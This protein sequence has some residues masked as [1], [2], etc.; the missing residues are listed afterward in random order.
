MAES[1][2]LRFQD[3][4]GDLLADACKDLVDVKEEFQCPPCVANPYASV[5][6]WKE[7]D[8]NEPFFNERK[9]KFE[10]T[11]ETPYTTTMDDEY[12][13]L[14]RA[15]ELTEELE[16]EGLN[17]RFDEF[18]DIA[19]ESLLVNNSREDS[20]KSRETV[21]NS[22]EYTDIYLDA[23]P[24][25]RLKL[26][27]SVSFETIGSIE[28]A[29]D[30]EEEEE[31]E[32]SEEEEE[33][34]S[35]DSPEA[36]TY[37]ADEIRTKLNRVRRGLKL[38]SKYLKVHRAVEG[39]NI[40]K[41]KDNSVFNLQNYGD[42]AR[43]G[44]ST[45]GKL[46][47]DLDDFLASK[48]L[49]IVAVGTTGL[50]KQKVT[51]IEFN[52]T[53]KYKLKRLRVW[54]AGCGEQPF[55][56]GPKKLKP[57]NAKDSWRDPTAVA[58]FAQ[59]DK[60][61]DSLTATEPM[62]W[63]EFVLEYTY[64][65]LYSTFG[66]EKE[67][68]APTSSCIAARL[69]EETKQLGQNILDSA[70]SIGDAVV[71]AFRKS[72]C[73]NNTQELEE[74]EIQ[75]GLR[76]APDA[77]TTTN[78]TK[79]RNV[80]GTKDGR[81]T[82][83]QMATEQAFAT[84][85]DEDQIFMSLCAKIA[86]FGKMNT[87]QGVRS[88]GSIDLDIIW[89]EGFDKIKKCGMFD[90]AIEA[91]HCLMKGLTLEQAGAAILKAALRA[92]SIDNLNDFFLRALPADRQQEVASL[93]R[94]KLDSGD[95]F[96]PGTE[97]SSLSAD[98]E[99]AEGSMAIITNPS[100]EE[101]LHE[102]ENSVE[103][104]NNAMIPQRNP[105]APTGPPKSDRTIA[106]T[107]DGSSTQAEF[108]NLIVVEAYI[109]ALIEI[110]RNDVIEAI[111][112]LNQYPGAQMIANILAFTDCP[113]APL[114]N[115][116]IPDFIN[117][118]QLPIC[119]DIDDWVMPRFQNPGAWLPKIKD[120]PK[121]F[122]ELFKQAL[123]Q[124][125]IG[126]VTKLIMKLCGLI[127]GSICQ[128]LKTAGSTLASLEDLAS[129]TASFKSAIRE[130]ICGELADEEEIDDTIADL[131][132]QLGA[133]SAALSDEELLQNFIS[134]FSSAVTQTEFM[135]AFLGNPSDEMLIAIDN[136]V[137]Y[138]YEELR[139]GFPNR[140]AIANFFENT[141][142]LIPVDVRD[143]MRDA[144]NN[145]P[146]ADLPANPSLC[147]TPEQQAAFCD[148]RN[149]LLQGR[150]SENQIGA[151]C[152][153]ATKDL[154]DN[155]EDLQDLLQGGLP[156]YINNNMPPLV[157]APGCD[158]GLIPFESEEAQQLASTIKDNTIESIKMAFLEDMLDNGPGAHN[159]G[160]MNMIL[161]D[162]KGNPLSAHH[163]YSSNRPNYVDYYT[164]D[165]DYDETFA[166][167]YKQE[168][169]YPYSVAMWLE[170]QFANG[171]LDT[172]NGGTDVSDLH[173]S[174]NYNSNNEY[175][176]NSGA[177]LS[178]TNAG[179]TSGLYD[180]PAIEL[181]NLP[182]L[183]YNTT[184]LINW[185][186]QA[187]HFTRHGRKSEPDLALEFRDNA[188]GLRAW[189]GSPYS[190]GFD[191][192]LYFG[193]LERG[194]SEFVS[195]EYASSG[196]TVHNVFSDNVR[197]MINERFNPAAYYDSPIAAVLPAKSH[198]EPNFP[199]TGTEERQ[200]EFFVEE[201]T[202]TNV[203]VTN[204]ATF[205]N[206][207][208]EQSEYSPQVVLLYD[209][210]GGEVERSSIKIVHDQFMSNAAK[211]FATSIATNGEMAFRYGMKMDTLTREDT[212][213]VLG[214]GYDDAGE[215]YGDAEI[216][217]TDEDGNIITRKIV[218]DDMILGISK[219]QYE[220]ESGQR[221]DENRVFYLDPATYGVSYMS[222]KIYIKPVESTGW[223]GIL[224][225]FFPELTECKDKTGADIINFSEVEQ[226][227]GAR[228]SKI[229]VDERLKAGSSECVVEKPYNRILTRDSAVAIEGIMV[230]TIR[231]F[232]ATH[233]IKSLAT[234]LTFKP[235]FTNVFSDLYASYIV[236]N[237]ELV[238]RGGTDE[239]E[240]GSMGFSDGEFWFAF[241]E[242]AV[243]SYGRRVDDG[244]IPD[245][246][247][248]ALAACTAINDMQ[249]SYAYPTRQ[250]LKN[251]K[252]LHEVKAFKTLKNYRE[253][254]NL[255]QVFY[256]R[257]E[258][259]I[260]L[261][262]LV[263]E[264]IETLVPNILKALKTT[265]DVSPAV[266]DMS[267][268]ILENYVQGSSLVLNEDTFVET[269][270][271]LPTE[272]VTQQYTYG[273][274]LSV[275]VVN[276]EDSEFIKG[277]EYVGYYHT[278]IDDNGDLFYMAGPEH[279]PDAHNI[280]KPFSTKIVVPIGE[281]EDYGGVFDLSNTEQPFIL[282]KYISINGQKY[283]SS[284]A[285]SKIGANENKDLN[286]ADVY[287]GDLELILDDQEN[288]IG[289]T[290]N[291]GVRYGLQLSIAI[292]GQ[293]A[294]I[295]E[296]E[297][298]ALDFPLSNF[299]PFQNNSKL[300]L[301]LINLLKQD[302]KFKLVCE[303]VFPMKK[304]VSAMAI[305][306][307]MGFLPSI[308]EVTVDDGALD[309]PSIASRPGMRAEGLSPTDPAQTLTEGYTPGWASVHDRNPGF[310]SGWF[311]REYDNWE[312][313]LLKRT[314]KRIKRL[315]RRN[316]NYVNLKLGEFPELPK[317][318][319]ILANNLRNS[320]RPATG[321]KLLPWWKRRK[322]RPDPYDS[323]GNK[324]ERE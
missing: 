44:N 317:P 254:K 213:Y 195:E 21:K 158:D 246:S 123:I 92:M 253:E 221:D 228:R 87:N 91:T 280:L 282:E 160:L 219:M 232:V 80:L 107:V 245:P 256:T 264:Q 26:L 248:A 289:I 109:S 287:P 146:E 28:E 231:I 130:S 66:E 163:R 67:T 117:S 99:K 42:L 242:Q 156:N 147:A 324:C 41:L 316:Y 240:D 170:K 167:L 12:L 17:K 1:K 6:S 176:D 122:F 311:V 250:D 208:V 193:D 124:L 127:S 226:I 271:D 141:G 268:H 50:F 23:R 277:E 286:L 143:A 197:I 59:L 131:F 105:S 272:E 188:K 27:Y 236:E 290:G 217:A 129:G 62:P 202:F 174:I 161:S 153:L 179:L 285:V 154:Q 291:I 18:L 301:C 93:A 11:V 276:E 94:A 199:G 25:S 223:V 184:A 323:E 247:A 97:L 214:F 74:L 148:L 305:Y 155:L 168:G 81:H 241:L 191:I 76:S 14:D 200:F 56:Y 243:Q 120:Y 194:P 294:A 10:V 273:G 150:A 266:E 20:L 48:D 65:G 71:Y 173:N 128:A 252:E 82:I 108:S 30:L 178:F 142:N 114:M 52:F 269:S 5:P 68:E 39:G 309:L 172:I 306:N 192:K 234:F 211:S 230:S 299:E 227:I 84:M 187:I 209:L 201:D 312:Q 149:S 118:I 244:D 177:I 100:S 225:A 278:H 265:L 51:R 112:L 159:W 307:D 151:M 293:R 314:K 296:V 233:F 292:E 90:F 218:N 83:K 61:N 198:I 22:I 308:G 34:E 215:I 140:Q 111:D 275:Y 207:F 85:E 133:G 157:S 297:I 144:I 261:K 53:S 262:E 180:K 70:F 104:P 73:L 116:S 95:I 24:T 284:Q 8:E 320:L 259:K 235:D 29:D 203:D 196:Y 58:Y 86:D 132:E 165:P 121:I 96:K 16:T 315:F 98:I 164:D 255:N 169:A 238:L 43:L 181:Y 55:I 49:N 13:E 45:L 220:V 40:L 134:D 88:L 69:E 222:P 212:E 64:P 38:Y 183:G 9:C 295:T 229:P 78:S 190:Y 322:L 185:D 7:L 303:Y 2:F 15:G 47:T 224:D 126:I 31:S 258:A 205:M 237:M 318:G 313:V 32:E 72:G 77:V 189:K 204:Y 304:I 136:L 270:T 125:I 101:I 166:S 321:E 182:D 152:D 137:G 79:L 281:V 35:E 210:L 283:S 106:Q 46:L 186:G 263:V 302:D 260:I 267:Y 257:K 102:R 300:L 310:W 135:N 57:L 298:D 89:T 249:E 279:V 113:Q 288:P 115:P 110:Y 251:A 139:E 319:R 4:D 145:P 216:E 274:E 63:I 33:E 37:I 19:V 162:T 206:C 54:A 103:G 239:H 171:T 119:S 175:G 3:M 138:E 60:M 36:V 75:L